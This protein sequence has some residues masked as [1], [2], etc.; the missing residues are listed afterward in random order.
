MD[1]LSSHSSRP[2][3]THCIMNVA[4]GS[5][6]KNWA[7]FFLCSVPIL[8]RY[9]RSVIIIHTQTIARISPYQDKLLHR[10]TSHSKQITDDETQVKTRIELGL[11]TILGEEK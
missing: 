6:V 7:Y 9:S 3:I 4:I 8:L 5:G 11:T 1:T 10:Q 2:S